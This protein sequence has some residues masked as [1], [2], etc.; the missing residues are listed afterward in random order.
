MSAEL[1]NSYSLEDL[2]ELGLTYVFKSNTPREMHSDE[3]NN[4]Y[5]FRVKKDDSYLYFIKK[6]DMYLPN[7]EDAAGL[8]KFKKL[9]E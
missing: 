2:E 1:T 6:D 7:P 8:E 4:L 3:G 5:I 9:I